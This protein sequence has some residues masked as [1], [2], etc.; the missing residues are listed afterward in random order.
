MSEDIVPL[1]NAQPTI[2]EL[3]DAV[4]QL[5]RLVSGSTPTPVAPFD[6][7]AILARIEVL[8]SDMQLVD[9]A[10]AL[11]TDQLLN[12]SDYDI[13]VSGVHRGYK[14][15]TA[16]GALKINTG[17]ITVNNDGNVNFNWAVPYITEVKSFVASFGQSGN[18]QNSGLITV[19]TLAGGTIYNNGSSNPRTVRYISV[20]I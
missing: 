9:Q 19:A 14:F 11:H 15:A 6:P 4:R 17:N 8:E 13:V 1:S 16:M 3:A 12:L 2:V 10:L 20:G 7:A 5:Q 18:N